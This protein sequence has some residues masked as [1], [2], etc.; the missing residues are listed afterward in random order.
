MGA[1]GCTFVFYICSAKCMY[2]VLENQ[3]QDFDKVMK[4]FLNHL[5][6]KLR[7]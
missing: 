5:L 7:L 2:F 6:A 1:N 4:V 3:N